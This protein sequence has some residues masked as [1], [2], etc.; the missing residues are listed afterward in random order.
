MLASCRCQLSDLA[1]MGLP[2]GNHRWFR[3]P[4]GVPVSWVERLHQSECLLQYETSVVEG[5][6]PLTSNYIG[7]YSFRSIRCVLSAVGLLQLGDAIVVTGFGASSGLELLLYP[8]LGQNLSDA[9]QNSPDS[10]A[11]DPQPRLDVLPLLGSYW[12]IATGSW[13]GQ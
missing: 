11:S 6:L 8:E 1:A 12:C 9:E 2:V 13:H 3:D 5:C 4:G 7:D 10:E